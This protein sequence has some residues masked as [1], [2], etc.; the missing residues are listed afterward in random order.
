MKRINCTSKVSHD[1]TFVLYFLWHHV[2]WKQTYLSIVK[3]YL[4]NNWMIFPQTIFVQSNCGMPFWGEGPTT[5]W[6][7]AR[8]SATPLSCHRCEYSPGDAVGS[9]RHRW[10]FHS[11]GMYSSLQYTHAAAYLYVSLTVSSITVSSKQQHCA[12]PCW[13]FYF[14]NLYFSFIQANLAKH[15]CLASHRSVQYIRIRIKKE[16]ILSAT[17]SCPVSTHPLVAQPRWADQPTWDCVLV[18]EAGAVEDA[19]LWLDQLRTGRVFWG[20]E[21]EDMS[22]PVPCCSLVTL[23]QWQHQQKNMSLSRAQI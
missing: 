13:I 12:E 14:K 1:K 17:G 15:T 19:G 8:T 6:L 7:P 10:H 21:A 5:Q 2:L 11:A 3:K 18:G 20:W 16:S 22:A 9:P 4:H 23:L